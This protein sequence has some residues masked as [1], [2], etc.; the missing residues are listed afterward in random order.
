[1]REPTGLN[2]PEPAP[3]SGDGPPIWDLVVADM[4]GRDRMGEAK[5]GTRLRAGNGRQPLVDAY[6]EVLD[7]AVYLRQELAERDAR[8]IAAAPE[9]LQVLTA[10]HLHLMVRPENRLPSTDAA[11]REMVRQAIEK[12][13]G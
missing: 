11:L 1:M 9:L 10:V 6:Q 13:G 7:L 3:T 12:A 8:L 5:Y 2:A 4:Q